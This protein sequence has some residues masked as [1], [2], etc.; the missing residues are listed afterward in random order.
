MLVMT[1]IVKLAA[2]DHDAYSANICRS[3]LERDWQ[4]DTDDGGGNTSNLRPLRERNAKRKLPAPRLI[5]RGFWL[6]RPNKR[7]GGSAEYML[8]E[9]FVRAFCEL[10]QLWTR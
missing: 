6:G 2:R 5:G 9:C 3:L 7:G 10:A 8:H 1:R 4:L